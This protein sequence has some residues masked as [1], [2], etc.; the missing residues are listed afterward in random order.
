MRWTRSYQIR[1]DQEADEAV[2]SAD[3]ADARCA[4]DVL[5]FLDPQSNHQV[6]SPTSRQQ[7]KNRLSTVK[8]SSCD[9]GRRQVITLAGVDHLGRY[10]CEEMLKFADLEP[11]IL[12]RQIS[13]VEDFPAPT[14][15]C[16]DQAV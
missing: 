8:S 13:P 14:E 6:S 1:P 5:S 15:H 9:S 4:I 3:R 11:I 7:Q 16:P 2:F 12:T 10:V